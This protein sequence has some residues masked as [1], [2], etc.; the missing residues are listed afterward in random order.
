[1]P[2]VRPPKAT[3]G[4]ATLTAS[5]SRGKSRTWRS[6]AAAPVGSSVRRRVVTASR[7]ELLAVVEVALGGGAVRG[8]ER[9]MPVV[10][11]A[12]LVAEQGQRGVRLDE[13]LVLGDGLGEALLDAVLEA[14]QAAEGGVVAVGGAGGWWRG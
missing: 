8:A 12:P 6:R 11:G 7:N 2:L 5:A 13:A 10:V 4:T 3:V 1:M 14:Q 9:G